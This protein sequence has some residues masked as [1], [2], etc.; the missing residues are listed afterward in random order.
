[1]QG[2]STPRRTLASKSLALGSGKGGTG[3]STTAVNIALYY[4]RKGIKTALFD[5]DPLSNIAVILDLVVPESVLSVSKAS[6]G[7]LENYTCPV[8]PNLDLIFPGAKHAKGDSTRLLNLTFG[9]FI[10]ELN[11]RYDFLIF[12]LPAGIGQEENLSFL[13]Y[14]K[15]LLVVTNP[16]PTAH[17]SSGGYI[18][19][20]LE[21]N[22]ALCIYLWHN[23]YK[24]DPS[25]PFNTRDVAGNYNRFAPPELRLTNE[26]KDKIKSLAFIPFDNTLNLLLTEVSPKE[27]ILSKTGDIVRII[28]DRVADIY[29]LGYKTDK[30]KE[31]LIRGYIKTDFARKQ[32]GDNFYPSLVEYLERIFRSSLEPAEKKSLASFCRILQGIPLYSNSGDV[33]NVLENCLEYFGRGG[34][35]FSSR[36]AGSYKKPDQALAGLVQSLS[37]SPL[38]PDIFL[39]NTAGLYLFSFSLY[40]LASV[41]SVERLFQNFFP[42]RKTASGGYVR[43]RYTQ[44]RSFY[45]KDE[46]YH[47][48]YYTLIKTLYPVILRQM[49]SIASALGAGGLVFKD[50]SGSLNKNLYLRLLMDMAHDTVHSGLGVF[51]GLR[52]NPASAAMKKAAEELYSYVKSP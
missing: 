22:P 2:I 8:V 5:L 4:A 37:A 7:R 10:E 21:I 34:A 30:I 18:K 32:S 13:P 29:P 33:L 52:F 36:P 11:R 50:K 35:A 24:V 39:R 3:K 47:K 46:T 28:R 15:T 26:E 44:I 27:V 45:E 23:R 20:A 42:K 6:E 1:M 12:D 43:D 51:P 9:S 16:E 49:D 48:R 41:E 40:R 19:A 38:R 14:I 17:V 25:L 31:R